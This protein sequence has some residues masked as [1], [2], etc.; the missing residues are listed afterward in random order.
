MKAIIQSGKPIQPTEGRLNYMWRGYF[1]LRHRVMFILR[2][3]GGRYE[4]KIIRA[5]NVNKHWN[6]HYH[7]QH[8]SLMNQLMKKL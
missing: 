6:Y 8:C 3:R 7:H 5:T 1:V 2:C 4:V